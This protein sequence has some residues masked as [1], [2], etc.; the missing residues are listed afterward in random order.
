M[1]LPG[2]Q[3]IPAALLTPTGIGM[4]SAG[5]TAVGAIFRFDQTLVCALVAAEGIKE[6]QGTSAV[7]VATKGAGA[8]P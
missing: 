2:C 1:L 8:A 5:F 3:V 7:C 6:Q 4:M